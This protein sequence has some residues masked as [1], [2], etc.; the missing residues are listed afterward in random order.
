MVSSDVVSMPTR[1][2]RRGVA[3]VVALQLACQC[4]QP[5]AMIVVMRC[6]VCVCVLHGSPRYVT[7]CCS[8]ML[9]V[10]MNHMLQFVM[11]CC[12]TTTT[13]FM[14]NTNSDAKLGLALDVLAAHH[15]C[16]I[17][18][19]MS[20]VL[21]IVFQSRL[22]LTISPAHS[23]TSLAMSL[24]AITCHDMPVHAIA[25]HS[26]H[27]VTLQAL[28]CHYMPLHATTFDYITPH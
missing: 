6:S 21:S 12:A 19:A 13:A 28:P 24:H 9:R 14:L 17:P 15:R 10:V 27:S 18:Y 22:Y 16:A 2:H 1:V 7:P 3:Y 8:T 11:L 25:C 5:F 4:I 23:I 20:Y 26:R